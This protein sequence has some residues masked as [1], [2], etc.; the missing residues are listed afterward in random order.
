MCAPH[1][2]YVMQQLR[3]S[4]LHTRIHGIQENRNSTKDI[5]SLVFGD[6][7]PGSKPGA[8]LRLP[9]R[10]RTTG[11]PESWAQEI[12]EQLSAASQAQWRAAT[13][14]ARLAPTTYLPDRGCFSDPLVPRGPSSPCCRRDGWVLRGSGSVDG[15]V[16]SVECC[17]E[18]CPSICCPIQ[19]ALRH[20]IKR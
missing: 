19:Q 13:A 16:G 3:W 14:S 2:Y 18:P 17:L 8:E 10:V 12:S 20:W 11:A 9:R 15:M 6:I 4:P 7:L 5:V 1:W